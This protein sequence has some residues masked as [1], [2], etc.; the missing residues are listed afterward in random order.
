M[1]IRKNRKYPRDLPA[2]PNASWLHPAKTFCRIDHC[3]TDEREAFS[4]ARS[5]LIYFA[6]VPVPR[7]SSPGEIR[8]KNID[9][10]TSTAP[11]IPMYR[12]FAGVITPRRLYYA[13]LRVAPFFLT[14]IPLIGSAY[15]LYQEILLVLRSIYLRRTVINVLRLFDRM[16]LMHGRKNDI[17]IIVQ[18]E[19]RR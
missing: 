6:A 17:R 9:R 11:R 8:G 3:S 19:D 12:R 18:K 2:K 10:S 1:K 7:L 14:A 4:F 13:Y 15:S 16:K 5:L